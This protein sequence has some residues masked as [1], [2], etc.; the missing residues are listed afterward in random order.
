MYKTG[1]SKLIYDI[2]RILKFEVT[3]KYEEKFRYTPNIRK[4][5]MFIYIWFIIFC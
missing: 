3:L 5:A 2:F 4:S 1:E